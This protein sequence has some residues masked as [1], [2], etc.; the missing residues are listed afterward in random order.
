MNVEI[1]HAP[2]FA[3]ATVTLSAGEAIR[4]EAG[5]MMTMS[6]DMTIETG[7][8]G[9]FL[10][11]LTRSLAGGESFFTNVFRPGAAGGVVQLVTA[12]PGDIATIEMD[13]SHAMFVQSGSFLAAHPDIDVDTKWGGAK[14]FFG[15]E[16]L[17]LLSCRGA[18]TMLVSSYGAIDRFVLEAGQAITVDSGHVVAFADTVTFN[19]RAVGGIKSTMLSGEGLVVDLAGQGEVFLQT[20]A[21]PSLADW[22]RRQ[23]PT[24]SSS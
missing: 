1:R 9:G 10:K 12:L 7:A 4:A 18:G 19:V 2:V 21:L 20:R 8:Q 16:G 14:T 13:G 24:Q 11:S 23:I 5:A 15:G 22:V 6:P 17:V 3:V